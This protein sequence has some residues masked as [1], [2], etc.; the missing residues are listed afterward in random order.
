VPAGAAT[1][2]VV[3]TIT[4]HSPSNGWKFTVSPAFGCQT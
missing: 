4:G 2:N 3:V 1:G